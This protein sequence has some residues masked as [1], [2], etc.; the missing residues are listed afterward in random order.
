[1]PS[2]NNMTQ[3]EVSI[4]IEWAAQEGWNPGI[5]DATSFYLADPKGFFISKLGDQAVAVISAVRYEEQF[6]FIG[7]YIVHPDYRGQGF[8]WEIWQV[9]MNHLQG[10]PI[11]LDGVVAQQSNYKKSGFEFANRN[12]RYAGRSKKIKVEADSADGSIVFLDQI[13][14]STIEAFDRSF[15]P[16]SRADFLSGWISQPESFALGLIAD[17]AICGYG[18]IRPC[19]IGFKI[20]PLFAN[21]ELAAEKL[22]SSLCACVDNDSPVFLDIPESNLRAINLVNRHQ[23]QPMFETARMYKGCVG[24]VRIED[25]YGITSFEL[26]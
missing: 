3:S 14:F 18:V 19:R 2:I 24:N 26:G 22:F 1:M 16:Q 13:P 11:G 4:A 25:T 12:I 21:S 15:F 17:G 20:G 5:S 9:A 10:I 7:L 6:G 8:G 23:M